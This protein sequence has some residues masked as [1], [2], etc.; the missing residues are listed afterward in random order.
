MRLLFALY[1]LALSVYPCSD[2][3]T[4]A[5]EQKAGI[6]VV[7]T[8]DHDH[9]QAEQDICTP[10]CICSCCAA[11]VQLTVSYLS[12]PVRIDHDTK[13]IIPYQ[14]KSLLNLPQSIWQPPKLS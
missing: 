10:L 2:K 3:G 13:L 12:M 1:I 14:E 8:S 4:C 9:T 11:S 5:D 6:A 7:D